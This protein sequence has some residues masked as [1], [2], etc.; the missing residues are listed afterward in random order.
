MTRT[1]RR[2]KILLRVACGLMAAAFV[3][4]ASAGFDEALK[5]HQASDFA[6]AQQEAQT[7][8]VAGD[9]R[10]SLLLGVMA[11]NGQGVSANPEQAVAHFE[12]AARG[13]IIGAYSKLAQAYARGAG[14]ARDRDRAITYA[15]QAARFGDL[16]GAFFL[17][18]LLTSE[19]LGY[20]NANGKTDSS[21]Y[22]HL[23]RR[24]MSERA[25]DTEAN[26]AL[27]WSAGRGFPM[28][29]YTLALKA[30]ATTGD[31]ARQRMLQLAEKLGPSVPQALLNYVKVGRYM[32]TLG[33]SYTSP[34]LFVD[35]QLIQMVAGMMKTCG[36][37][38]KGEDKSPTATL[39]GVRVSRPLQDAVYLPSRIPGYDRASLIAGHWEEEWTYAGCERT[40]AVAVKF[41]ADGL[42]G[43]RMLSEQSGKDI[44][45]TSR[46]TDVAPGKE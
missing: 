46:T 2:M 5:A 22:F 13:G 32:E 45:G 12:K 10:A 37:Q 24:P 25:V 19:Y 38:K 7:A 28:A 35:T 33:E 41:V 39:V 36:I 16:E 6:V 29:M 18:V 8:A 44:P 40:A 23:A 30:A 20:M 15:R 27:Y 42:G 1:V 34:Q 26:D 9:A 21:K 31:G 11:Q 17:S 4:L 43:A 3:P 14:V